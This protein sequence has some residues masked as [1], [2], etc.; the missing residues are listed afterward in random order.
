MPGSSRLWVG[1]GSGIL[2]SFTS[3]PLTTLVGEMMPGR[4]RLNPGR[5]RASLSSGIVGTVVKAS[6]EPNQVPP[7]SCFPIA[8]HMRE[9]IDTALSTVLPERDCLAFGL[10]TFRTSGQ[11]VIAADLNG[12]QIGFNKAGTVLKPLHGAQGQGV[13]TGTTVVANLE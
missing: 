12:E 3:V 6:E 7:P 8:A 5:R 10:S 13:V 9:L 1:T 2:R 11:T 4:R